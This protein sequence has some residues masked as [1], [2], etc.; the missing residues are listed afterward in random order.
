MTSVGIQ[1]LTA[2]NYH[3]VYLDKFGEEIQVVI[4]EVS[5]HITL[6][7]KTEDEIKKNLMELQAKINAF[8]MSEADQSDIVSKTLIDLDTQT[9]LSDEQVT[10]VTRTTMDVI[11]EPLCKSLVVQNWTQIL[12]T[13]LSAMVEGI[14]PPPLYYYETCVNHVESVLAESMYSIYIMQGL[15]VDVF[16]QDRGA[17][18]AP[19]GGLSKKA[20]MEKN[21]MIAIIVILCTILLSVLII[22]VMHADKD[23]AKKISGSFKKK[24]KKKSSSNVYE[25]PM[26][27]GMSMSMPM[28]PPPYSAP[29]PPPP[30]PEEEHIYATIDDSPIPKEVNLGPLNEVTVF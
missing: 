22:G 9:S 25:E 11:N 29:L 6:K 30:A 27:M 13:D 15:N 21:G 16:N 14:V 8:V 2:I 19:D 1:G 10:E 3:N 17:T 18:I 12:L 28:A 20:E 5:E 7:I 26:G 23:L 4:R 24:D